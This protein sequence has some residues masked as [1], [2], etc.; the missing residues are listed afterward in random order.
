MIESVPDG[1]LGIPCSRDDVDTTAS[2]SGGGPV[3]ASAGARAVAR[4]AV[5]TAE[6][7]RRSMRQRPTAIGYLCR[8]VSGVSREWHEVRIR[9]MARRIADHRR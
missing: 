3:A 5:V 6:Q 4:R 2:E 8:D 9:G 7:T 1:T